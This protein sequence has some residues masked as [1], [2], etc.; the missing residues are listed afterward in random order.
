MDT[1]NTAGN[2]SFSIQQIDIFFFFAGIIDWPV[3]TA[4]G[5]C[6]YWIVL[7]LITSFY[8]ATVDD[9]GPGFMYRNYGLGFDHYW[10]ICL[11]GYL[12]AFFI[13]SRIFSLDLTVLHKTP[14]HGLFTLR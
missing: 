14:G 8:F 12:G 1:I 13:K 6:Y 9:E 3:A 5:L 11:L 7:L 10:G 4:T 2:E